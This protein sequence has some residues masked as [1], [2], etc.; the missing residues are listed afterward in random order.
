MIVSIHQPNYLPFLGYFY[1]VYQSDV[2]VFLDD[3]QYINDGLT[4][5]NRIKTP[6]GECRLKIPVNQ[7][8][9]DSINNVQTRD[10][11]KWKE[12]HLK[13]IL[14]NYKK[15]NYF[16]TVFP[17][18]TDILLKDYSSISEL[19]I[20]IN[21]WIIK[22]F[23]FA[24]QII[25]SSKLNINSKKEQRVIDIVS[26]LGGTKYISG[27]GAKAYQDPNHFKE[28]GITLEYSDYKAIEYPQLWG[29]VGFVPNLSVLDYIMNCGF[30]WGD[31]VMKL[32]HRKDRE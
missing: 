24:A 7:H 13:T 12:K 11:L 28:R 5:W 17:M 23:G 26:C 1:K 22:Q 2:F 32:H 25:N 10:E 31:V 6:Q 4:N 16:D 20:A 14:M 9:G 18:L 15:A 27:N 3:V 30:D 21:T 19:N 8:F 29:K